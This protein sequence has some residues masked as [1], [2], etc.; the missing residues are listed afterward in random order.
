MTSKLG[1]YDNFAFANLLQTWKQ[2]GNR[3][4]SEDANAEAVQDGSQ[5]FF[6]LVKHFVLTPV[7]IHNLVV[8][9]FAAAGS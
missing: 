7:S 5:Q 6:D 2:S 4:I 3:A 1:N 9:K 8:Q